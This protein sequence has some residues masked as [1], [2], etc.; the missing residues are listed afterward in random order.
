VFEV[1][2]F[3]TFIALLAVPGY[4]AVTGFAPI[5]TKRIGLHTLRNLAHF[6]GQYC[7]VFAIGALPLATVFAIEF[8]MPVWTALLAYFF[9]GE[10]LTAPRLVML[11]LGLVGVSVIL[12]PGVA[13]IQPAA[14]VMVLGALFYAAN[15]ITTK[16]LTT[17]DRALATLF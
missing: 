5:R 10:R 3:R 16:R 15:M 17:T 2:F 7:W 6:T 4:L 12:R 9:L 1:L 11:T 14:F 8:T 13:A